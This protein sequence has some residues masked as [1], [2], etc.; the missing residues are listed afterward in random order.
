MC[1]ICFKMTSLL[2]A[3]VS[4]LANRE[5]SRNKILL[6]CDSVYHE[7]MNELMNK[8]NRKRDGEGGRKE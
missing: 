4:F 5:E 8:K 2:S 7:Q 1:G 6:R 3:F